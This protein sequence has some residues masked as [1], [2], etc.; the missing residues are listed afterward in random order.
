VYVD[1]DPTSG[2]DGGFLAATGNAVILDGDSGLGTFNLSTLASVG[3][4]SGDSGNSDVNIATDLK[5]ATAYSIDSSVGS[6]F[7]TLTQLDADGNTTATTVTLSESVAI[8]GRTFLISGYGWLGV[9]DAVGG[10]FKTIDP[11]TG[12]VNDVAN[13][14][15]LSDFSVEPSTSGEDV[16]NWDASGVGMFDGTDYWY[17]SSDTDGNISKFS[18]TGTATQETMLVNASASPS[19]LDSDNFTISVSAGRFYIHD[20]SPQS[21]VFGLSSVSVS[22][23]IISGEA[24]FSSGDTPPSSEPELPNTG[25]DSGM[26]VAIAALLAGLG[27]IAFIVTRRRAAT[28]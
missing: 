21:D 3:T 13:V 9:W 19:S 6:A 8:G 25:V 17:V 7:A 12:T 18:I 16:G 2:D 20:E 26:G 14:N 5:T 15:V 23:G 11:T 4:G 22:E 1:A 28:K 10:T 27:A 24:T